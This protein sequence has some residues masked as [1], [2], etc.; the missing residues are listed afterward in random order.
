MAK[1]IVESIKSVAQAAVL[2]FSEVKESIKQATLAKYATED[3]QVAEITDRKAHPPEKV[4]EYWH[5]YQIAGY[6]TTKASD[7]AN[8]PDERS[9]YGLDRPCFAWQANPDVVNDSNPDSF[10]LA[11]AE[12]GKLTGK[13][14]PTAELVKALNKALKID[15]EGLARENPARSTGARAVQKSAS[16]LG[17]IAGQDRMLA[18]ARA[19]QAGNFAEAEKLQAEM[20]QALMA[21]AGIVEAEAEAEGS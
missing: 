12:Y 5:K 11:I 6:G 15:A 18:W 17:K 9:Y 3:K 8:M 20:K 16:E 21:E 4:G 1:K 14:V 2:T 10:A 13:Q 19:M 7:T